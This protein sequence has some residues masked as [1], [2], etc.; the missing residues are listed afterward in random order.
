[1]SHLFSFRNLIFTCLAL[2]TNGTVTRQH[3]TKEKYLFMKITLL[4]INIAVCELFVY[5]SVIIYRD[6]DSLQSCKLPD[7]FDEIINRSILGMYVLVE[8]SRHIPELFSTR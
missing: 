3:C 5:P 8:I 1:M 6:I 2:D 7:S 4:V